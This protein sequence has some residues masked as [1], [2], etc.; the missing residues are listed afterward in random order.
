MN[1]L[2]GQPSRWQADSRK[3][4]SGNGGI[5]MRRAVKT[6][7]REEILD[8]KE[9]ASF[10]HLPSDASPERTATSWTGVLAKNLL[11]E[12]WQTGWTALHAGRGRDASWKM[13][14]AIRRVQKT[15]HL[16]V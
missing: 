2:H 3:Q 4:K 9:T 10:A 11:R 7:I 5:L 1:I 12:P 6:M 15:Q 16:E 13:S 8:S 14:N